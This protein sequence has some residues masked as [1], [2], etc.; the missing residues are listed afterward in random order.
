MLLGRIDAPVIKHNRISCRRGSMRRCFKWLR[1]CYDYSA[2]KRAK[3][4]FCQPQR[5]PCRTNCQRHQPVFARSRQD[6]VEWQ[7]CVSRF[8]RVQRKQAY[9]V[10]YWLLWMPGYEAMARESFCNQRRRRLNEHFVNIKVDRDE[11][12][13]LDKVY[14][15]V[16]QLIVLKSGGGSTIF[17]A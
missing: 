6:L 10:N 9:F 3:I 8:S 2:L 13:D 17:R 14:Q 1:L 5:M 12:P 4:P 11:R 7:E 15:S 16:L